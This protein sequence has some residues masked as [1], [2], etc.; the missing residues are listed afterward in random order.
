MGACQE[1]I[2]INMKKDKKIGGCIK[3]RTIFGALNLKND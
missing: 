3:K 2:Y 1:K